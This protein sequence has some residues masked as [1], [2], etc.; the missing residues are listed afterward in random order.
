MRV[1]ARSI[2]CFSETEKIARAG[3]ARIDE[4]GGAAAPGYSIGIDAERSAAPIDVGVQIDQSR[5]DDPP[6][7]IDDRC[8]S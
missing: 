6:G 7:D 4:C 1:R 2:T 3:A 5:G 8:G